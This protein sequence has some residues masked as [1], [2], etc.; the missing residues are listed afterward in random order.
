MDLKEISN[1]LFPG[2]NQNNNAERPESINKNG[3]VNIYQHN[4]YDDIEKKRINKKEKPLSYFPESD[5]R[6]IILDTETTGLSHNDT[7]ISISAIEVINKQITG[8]MYNAYFHPR[9]SNK[10]SYLYY[11]EDYA[12]ERNNNLKNCMNDF[13]RFV[14]DSMIITHNVNFDLMFI[15]KELKNLNMKEIPLNKCIC[16]LKITRKWRK[17]GIYDS[18]MG[19]TLYDLS[20]YYNIRTNTKDF[21]HGIFDSFILGRIICKM[22]D[23]QDKI[24]NSNFYNEMNIKFGNEDFDEDEDNNK[25]NE[26]NGF[27]NNNY[28]NINIKSN[29]NNENNEGKIYSKN[30]KDNKE[31]N[32][33]KNKEEKKDGKKGVEIYKEN[34]ENNS[35]SKKKKN[36]KENNNL[37]INEKFKIYQQQVNDKINNN[38]YEN[39]KINIHKSVM[40]NEN[41]IN[42]KNINN[43]ININNEDP[44]TE[45]KT[46][47]RYYLREQK[48]INYKE[49]SD[50][51]EKKKSKKSKKKNKKP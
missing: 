21:H 18:N 39:D 11:I 30:D 49:E 45:Q 17:M 26:I 47:E 51:E 24:K 3:K 13:I 10:L 43:N 2:R 41:N 12:S 38:K 31:R 7:L 16:S 20:K 15:N 14:G 29:G 8:I 19:G 9:E 50:S 27:V 28:D 4:K 35:Q 40:L 46:N 32:K 23:H 34:K 33:S 37:N 48:K 5:K 36:E 1:K 44:N 22:W 6:Y 25:E 42:S